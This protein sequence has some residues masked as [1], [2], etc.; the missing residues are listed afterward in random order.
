MGKNYRKA[1]VGV[2]VNVSNQVLVLERTDF[3]GS[4]QLPQG[5]V[6]DGESEIDAIKREMFEELGTREFEVVSSIDKT[7]IYDFPDDLDAK[8][9]KKYSGQSLKWFLLKFNSMAEPDLDSAQDKEFRDFKWVDWINACESIT[10]WKKEAYF[11][12]FELL[13]FK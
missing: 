3:P 4:W 10:Q 5:G 1:V 8:I 11:E 6:D 7:T 2:F 13:G 12:G 9:A